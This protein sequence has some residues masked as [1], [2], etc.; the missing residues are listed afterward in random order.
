LTTTGKIFE[1]RRY[2]TAA[3]GKCKCLLVQEFL[4]TL[5]VRFLSLRVST[6][7]NRALPHF[8]TNLR[9]GERHAEEDALRKG[10][11]RSCNS[12]A[13]FLQ[14]REQFPCNPNREQRLQCRN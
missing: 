6:L 2:L 9:T 7:V 13:T 3:N 5:D 4:S 11:S 14:P 10:A 1:R 8:I 12:A